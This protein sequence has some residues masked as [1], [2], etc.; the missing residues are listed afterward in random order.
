MKAQRIAEGALL[1]LSVLA[2]GDG[3]G[4]GG[5]DGGAGAGDLVEVPGSARIAVGFPDGTFS[6]DATEAALEAGSQGGFHIPIQV[7][8]DAEARSFFGGRA[9]HERTARRVRDGAFL[10]RSSFDLLFDEAAPGF[11]ELPTPLFVFL[12]PTPIDVGVADEALQIRVSVGDPG[13]F[14][15]LV[16]TTTVTA[17]CPEGAQRAFCDR[18]CRG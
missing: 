5:G 12:C 2:C 9:L 11:Y 13:R 10:G 18:I 3:D 1:V 4:D 14:V 8:L 17:R 16:A 7:R 6:E 15:P